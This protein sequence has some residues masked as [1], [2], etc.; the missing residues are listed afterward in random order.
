[1]STHSGGFLRFFDCGRPVSLMRSRHRLESQAPGRW[2]SSNPARAPRSL[3]ARRACPINPRYRAVLRDHCDKDRTAPKTRLTRSRSGAYKP[4]PCG[5][6]GLRGPGV[7]G[8]LFDIVNMGRDAQ[9]AAWLF[10]RASLMRVKDRMSGAWLFP[11][12]ASGEG[13]ARVT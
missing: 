13:V 7:A 9:A 1:M 10:A 5:A 6:A 12:R 8:S 4:P 11:D 3:R 2:S